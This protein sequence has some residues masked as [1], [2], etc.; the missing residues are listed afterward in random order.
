MD[1][2]RGELEKMDQIDDFL[3]WSFSEPRGL[4]HEGGFVP[5]E[6][7]KM[8]LMLMSIPDLEVRLEVMDVTKYGLHVTKYRLHV[9]KYRLNVTKYR[10]HVTKYRLNVTKYKL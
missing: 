6:T 7:E 9:T 2:T 5:E 1:D 10:L 4:N 3:Y 8:G